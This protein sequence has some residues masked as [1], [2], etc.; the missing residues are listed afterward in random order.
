MAHSTENLLQVPR[1]VVVNDDLTQMNILCGLLRK[2]NLE[3]IAFE[4]AENALAAM[5]QSLVPNLVVT[6]IYM[7]NI[8]G[9]KFCRL[10]RSA[11]YRW[12]NDVPILV[13]SAIFSGDEPSRITS[14]LGAN[15]FLPM[16]VDGQQ[17]IDNVQNLLKGEKSQHVL[18]ALVVETNE[19]ISRL[20][21]HAFQ[22]HG[23]AVDSVSTFQGG[24]DRVNLQDYDVAV[25]DYLLPDGRGDGLLKALQEKSPDCVNIIITADEQ[26]GLALTWMKMGAASYLQKPFDPEYLIV[27]CERHRRERALLRIQD[28]LD[29]RTRQL[30]ESER[31]FRNAMEATTDG[32]WE[33]DITS[34]KSYF[35]PAYF[36]MLGYS[37]DELPGSHDNWDGSLHPD[38]FEAVQAAYKACQQNESSNFDI[39]FRMRVRDGSWRWIRSRGKAIERDSNGQALKMIGTHINITENKWGEENRRENEERL[40]AIIETSP[41]AVGLFDSNA[42]ILLMNPAAAQTFGYATPDEMVGLNVFEFFPPESHEK[43]ARIINQIFTQGSV[44]NAEFTLLRKNKTSFASEFSCSALFAQDGTPKGIVA[45]TRDISSRKIEEQRVSQ[46]AAIVDSSDDAIFSTDLN[47]GITSWNMGAHKMFGYTENEIL[48]KS[49]STLIPPEHEEEM[50]QVLGKIRQ[51]ESIEHFESVTYGKKGKAIFVSMSISPIWNADGEVIGASTIARDITDRKRVEDELRESEDDLKAVFNATDESIF[52]LAADMTLLALNDVAAQRL[53]RSRDELIGRKMPT[54][55]PEDVVARRQPYIERALLGEQVN[56]EDQRDDHWMAN[57]LHPILAADGKV[58]RLAIYSQDITDRKRAENALGESEKRYRVIFEGAKEGIMVVNFNCK[59]IQYANPAVCAMFGYTQEAFLQLTHEDLF[60]TDENH[61]QIMKGTLDIGKG[62]EPKGKVIQCRH[63]DGRLFYADVRASELELNGEKLFVSFINDVTERRRNEALLQARLFLG[64][65]S[66]Q[67]TL[68]EMLQAVLDQAEKITDSQIGFFHFIEDDQ[69]T[70]SLQT[71]STNTLQNMCTAEGKGQHYPMDQA[72]VWAECLRTGEAMIYN[73]YASLTIRKGMPAGHAPVRRFISIPIER[74]GKVVA[75]I[76]VGNKLSNYDMPDVEV[77]SLLA[78]EAWDLVLRLRADTARRESEGKYRSLMECQESSISTLDRHGVFHYVNRIAAATLSE[79][80]LPE[81]IIGRNMSEFFPEPVFN[82]QMDLVR[83]VIQGGVG[84]VDES[85]SIVVGRPRWYRTS[86]QPLRDA[87][88]NATLAMVNAVDITGL[89]EAEVVL[90]EKVKDRT[91]E[92]ESVRQR[93]ELAARTAGLG[94]WDWNLITGEH[95]WDEGMYRIYNLEPG[96]YDHTTAGW[97]QYVHPDDLPRERRLIEEMLRYKKAYDSEF[98][99][100]CPDKSEHYIKSNALTLE[101][102][103]G[104]PVRIIGVS[105]DI[106]HHKQAENVLR[107]SQDMLQKA[108]R[109]LERAMVMKD[110]FLASMSHELRTP[111]TWIL[112]LSESLQA[113]TYGDLNEKQQAAL[114]NIES[115]GIHLLELINDILDVSKIEAGKLELQ[116]ENCNLVDLCQASLRMVKGM[117]H[118]KNLLLNFSMVPAT[119]EIAVDP[120]RLKQILVNL[121]S[122]AIK[123]TPKNGAMGLEVEGNL[124]TRTLRLTVWDK[125]IGIKP[126]DLNRLFQPFLQLDS[127][128]SRQQNGTGLGL[129]L[130]KRLVQLHGGS[131]Q[132]ESEFGHG[133]RFSVFLPWNSTLDESNHQKMMEDNGD[134]RVPLESP[135]IYSSAQPTSPDNWQDQST[136]L[137]MLVD[138]DERNRAGIA[139]YLE[140]K[141]IRV[142]QI[143]NGPD[144][145]NLVSDVQPDIVFLDIQMPDMDGLEVIQRV[146]TNPDQRVA[147]IPIIAMTALA[148]PKD[149]KRCLEAGANEYISKPVSMK[150]LVELINSVVKN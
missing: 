71:W 126:E 91:S 10:L 124:K 22:A 15:A 87:A 78:S 86:I 96:K 21:T 122:N 141:K 51:A 147:G 11:E 18:K 47:G 63:R 93:L 24:M 77:V 90:E 110:E 62:G 102:E 33:R 145:L 34:G 61:G 92:I 49:V 109:E 100:T 40:R 76:G 105:Y 19:I 116:I 35:S 23:Y 98:R 148:M 125:G 138:D 65:L 129:A 43:A 101:N 5:D 56:F 39:D 72:G 119:V 82:Y 42:N 144:F 52:L 68:D 140:M 6:D 123:F 58:A 113:H 112:G 3:P 29:I 114:A 131:I 106:T 7:P 135:D 55:I 69:V 136:P 67:I 117:A 16:P 134:G 13:V 121:L 2:T 118:Q 73:D 99:I 95:H 146:R 59:V 25:L 32:L 81:N 53:G 45:I 31:R 75:I 97:E 104:Q 20:I 27:Q 120:R 85:R 84:I 80:G 28:L 108:N 149:R 36:T 127:S 128:L 107:R 133:S 37:P 66:A 79:G 26:P 142:I 41:D 17:F 48:D 137:I 94:I 70:I 143:S 8:D 89:K 4:S 83:Q 46:L 30:Q 12:L 111:S 1:V 132:V 38:D 14:E 139:D 103:L 60:S 44:R 64:N 150:K 9:W 74:N 57:H 115:C 54:L 88:G 130:V 50:P